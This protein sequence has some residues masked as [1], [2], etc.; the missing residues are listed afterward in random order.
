MRIISSL[1]SLIIYLLSHQIVRS[2]LSYNRTSRNRRITIITSLVT[3][4]RASSSASIK[5][6]VTVD[7]FPDF[8]AI[9]P[10]KSVNSE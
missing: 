10:P 8:Q 4:D 7:Y 9:G 1:T 3:V 6:V 5:N 2:S